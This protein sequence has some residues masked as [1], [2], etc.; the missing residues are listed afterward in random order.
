[1]VFSGFVN[2]VTLFQK[3]SEMLH[4]ESL[5]IFG[6]RVLLL[7]TSQFAIYSRDRPLGG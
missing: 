6:T 1:M 2:T 7:F 5:L 4:F 3:F